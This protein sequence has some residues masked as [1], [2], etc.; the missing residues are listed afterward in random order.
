MKKIIV[1]HPEKQH[2][3]R[4]AKAIHGY[5]MLEEYV[6]TV[7]YKN[8][9]LTKVVD[10][11]T[12]RR[13]SLSI[14]R[15]IE[16][17]P[18]NKVKQYYELRGLFLL[19]MRHTRYHKFINWLQN[20]NFDKFG[21]KV[22]ERAIKKK[23]DAVVMYDTN[24]LE[25]FKKIKGEKKNIKCIMD[26]S[27]ANRFYTKAIYEKVIECEKDW[28]KFSESRVLLNK[29]EM[30]RLLEEINLTDYFLVPSKFVKNSL[31]YSG[32]SEEKIC[33]VPYGVDIDLFEYSERRE[34]IT[35]GKLNILFVGQCSYR[36]GINYL[37]KAISEMQDDVALTIVGGYDNITEL[38]EKYSK[39]ENI[40]F[41]GR[42]QH[43]Q[44]PQ[45]YKKADVFALPSLSEGM[46][47]VGLE[48]MACGVPLLCSM[49]CGVNDVVMQGENGWILERIDSES[50]KETLK[51]II[52]NRTKLPEMGRNA[53]LTAENYSWKVYEKNMQQALEKILGEVK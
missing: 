48:A 30:A 16:D 18:T 13:F 51:D 3:H 50:I 38:Y 37:L 21:K 20:N 17:I 33:I 6:T 29:Q 32:V 14:S 41:C 42:V 2:S 9:N 1:A 43:S 7:Y 44:L 8:K 45:I 28:E 22:A 36:K 39:C 46:S 5:G 27:I 19:V 47:L 24:S 10:G 23:V 12:R 49:N 25:C 26:T 52:L 40:K 31:I 34:N 4:L 11:L 15:R 53:R 35:S